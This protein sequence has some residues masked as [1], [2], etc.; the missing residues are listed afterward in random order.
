MSERPR[1]T[2][3]ILWYHLREFL[4]VLIRLKSILSV[5][6][7]ISIC[8]DCSSSYLTDLTN[9]PTTNTRS[10]NF[11]SNGSHNLLLKFIPLRTT[12]LDLE[13]FTSRTPLLILTSHVRNISERHNLFPHL[14]QTYLYP[15][16][17]T[18]GVHVTP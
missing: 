4:V 2:P 6:H 11:S 7:T 1:P 8:S 14:S 18:P 16:T 3:P 12:S 13:Q 5:P 15:S 9:A 17:R 10:N